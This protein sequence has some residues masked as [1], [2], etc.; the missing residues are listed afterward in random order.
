MEGGDRDAE[1]AGVDDCC[2]DVLVLL[3]SAP[4]PLP[5][6]LLPDLALP[7]SPEVGVAL[8]ADVTAEDFCVDVL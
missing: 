5:S 2:V 1:A 6:A 7:P 4:P 8:G 3:A